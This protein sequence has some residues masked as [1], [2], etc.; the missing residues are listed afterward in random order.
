MPRKEGRE[1][2]ARVLA[3]L[4]ERDDALGAY[5][6]LER[7][8]AAGGRIAP[9]TVYR[10]LAALV[11]AGRVHR[12]E[13][14]NAYVACRDGS[15]AC[16]RTS[17]PVFSICEDCGSVEEH[18]APSLMRDL[19]AGVARRGFKAVQPVIEVRGRCGTC[20]EPGA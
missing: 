17:P 10:A 6:V 15:G 2:Q 5:A 9:P 4:E 16:G 8:R 7:L 14:A 1:M 3:I 12:I 18:D 20:R 13:S 19:I 11:E